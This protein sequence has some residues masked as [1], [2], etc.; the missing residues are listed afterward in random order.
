MSYGYVGQ[1]LDAAANEFCVDEGAEFG[2][3]GRQDLRQLLHLDDRQPAR[4]ERLGQLKT[5][6]AG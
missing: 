6:A 4:R 1:Y 3:D 2:I 5:D